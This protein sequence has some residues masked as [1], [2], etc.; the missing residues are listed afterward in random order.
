M[1]ATPCLPCEE[2]VTC[3]VRWPMI[4][5]L[6]P[7]CLQGKLQVVSA[8]LLKHSSLHSSDSLPSLIHLFKIPSGSKQG[9]VAEIPVTVKCGLHIF[10]LPPSVW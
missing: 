4:F 10:A 7:A 6:F 1:A 5:V 9:L 3:K 8:A 2:E